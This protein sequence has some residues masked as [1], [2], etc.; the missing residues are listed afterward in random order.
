MILFINK[1]NF[2]LLLFMNIELRFRQIVTRLSDHQKLLTLGVVVPKMHAAVWY[3]RAQA[4][5]DIAVPG[6][7]SGTGIHTEVA[8][9]LRRKHFLLQGRT[10]VRAGWRFL[11]QRG[12]DIG[13][14]KS[15]TCH[16]GLSLAANA[17]FYGITEELPVS[18]KMTDIGFVSGN[19]PLR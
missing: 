9:V 15:S 1:A 7:W 10:I 4:G 13:L 14:E 2:F 18:L 16:G 12:F 5:F 11:G 19:G 3:Q 6:L 17:S 8:Y